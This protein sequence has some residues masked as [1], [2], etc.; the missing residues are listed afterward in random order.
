[1]FHTLPGQSG[2]GK[3]PRKLDDTMAWLISALA[4]DTSMIS[5]HMWIVDSTPIECSRSR[6]AVK[7]SDLVGWAEHGYCASHS[8][9]FWGLGLYL[10][11]TPST[12]CHSDGS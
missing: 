2:Y 4:T 11:C 7:R 3:R 10:A 12:T 9:F 1:M 6:E 8:W 5:D